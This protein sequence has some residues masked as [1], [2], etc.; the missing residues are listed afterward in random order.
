MLLEIVVV[1][2]YADEKIPVVW[3][4][5]VPNEAALM[6]LL[7]RVVLPITL[8]E[9]VSVLAQHALIPKILLEIKFVEELATTPPI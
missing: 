4:P 8:F 1:F 9:M 6:K 3:P 7:A 2:K 5:V